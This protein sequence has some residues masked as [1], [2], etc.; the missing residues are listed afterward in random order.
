MTRQRLPFE[1][2]L[3]L[4]AESVEAAPHVRDPGR[5]PDPRACG[6]GDHARRP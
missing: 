6:K 1:H 2:R 3:H 5:D 4:G